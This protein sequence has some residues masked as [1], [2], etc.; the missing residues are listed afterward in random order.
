MN[1]LPVG[2]YL[3]EE[4]QSM[5]EDCMGNLCAQYSCTVDGPQGK[6][7]GYGLGPQEA[8]TCA[9][10]L[11]QDQARF[12]ALSDMDKCKEILGRGKKNGR[13]YDKDLVELLDSMFYLLNN[14]I[15]S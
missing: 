3:V 14:S 12:T 4:H 15:K 8:K 11:A 7:W 10:R 9:I 1:E 6:L 13:F 5:H 2:Y